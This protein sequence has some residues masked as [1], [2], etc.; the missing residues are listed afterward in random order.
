MRIVPL[1]L[2]IAQCYNVVTKKRADAH[3]KKKGSKY[4]ENHRKT[5]YLRK[6]K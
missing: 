6:R 2:S 3:D 4:Y 1:S 5:Y